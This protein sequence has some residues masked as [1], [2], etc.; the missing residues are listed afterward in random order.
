MFNIFI[1]HMLSFGIVKL[2]HTLRTVAGRRRL[3]L[4]LSLT[5]EG[6]KTVAM[7]CYIEKLK[8]TF[9]ACH[10]LLLHLSNVFSVTITKINLSFFL[11][12]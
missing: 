12:Q 9:F 3:H 4:G 2:I 8:F 10:V 6:F 1:Q 11:P 7:L 5:K